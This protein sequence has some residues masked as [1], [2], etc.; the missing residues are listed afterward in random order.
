MNEM[1][2]PAF[3]YVIY[4]RATA[5]KV[6][7]ALTTPEMTRQY[8]SNHRNRSDWRVG[9]PWQHEDHDDA[10]LVD[11]SGTILESVASRRLGFTWA[12]PADAKAGMRLSR[13]L[14]ETTEDDGV[15]RLTLT[16]DQLSES[17]DMAEGIAEGWPL[18]LSSLKSLLETG[19]ALPELWTRDGDV[20]TR[21]SFV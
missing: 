9:S 4:I 2:R 18:V 20:W 10:S 16:H 17:S 15:V 12:S 7:H 1:D 13:V 21:N 6:W 5:D 8:W 14:F 3:V 11:I 19:A